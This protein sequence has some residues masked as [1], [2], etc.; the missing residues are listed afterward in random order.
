MFD[1]REN[2]KT[3]P[4]KPGVYLHKDKYGDVIYVGKASSLKNRVNQ[5]FHAS[6]RHDSKTSAMVEHIVEFEYIVTQTEMEALLLENNLI[7]KYL[8]KYNVMLRDD[9]TYPYIKITINEKYPRLLKTRVLKHDGSKYFGPY[10]DVLSVNR[11]LDLLNNIYKL[12]QCSNTSFPKGFRPCLNG[13]IDKCRK[14]CVDDSQHEEYMKDINSVMEFLKGKSGDVIS[15]LTEKMK[16]ASESQDYENA[17]IYRDFILSARSV[18][19]KQRVELLSTGDI[20]IVLATEASDETMAQVTLFFV[21][22]GRLIGRELH[23]LD[24]SPGDTK[25]EIVSAFLA[26]YYVNQT[27]IPKEILLEEH[28]PDEK[29][30]AEMLTK[31]A[32]RNV[33]ISI[34]QKGK[35]RALLK[36]TQDDVSE[37]KKLMSDRIAHEQEKEKELNSEI[38]RTLGISNKNEGYKYRLEAYDI[39]NTG[40]ADS[41]GAMVVF[42]GDKPQKR[43]YRKFKVRGDTEGDD[44]AA[45][46]EVVYR[47]LKRGLE[48]DKGFSIMPDLI[49]VDGGLGHVNAVN[50]ILSTL[51]MDISVAGMVKDDKHRTR[52]LIYEGDEIHLR[53]YPKLYHLIGSIQEE[54]HRFVI[55]YH[56][57][58]RKK[59]LIKSELD[60]IPG[61]G[62]KRRNALL[63]AFGNIDAIKEAD[64]DSIAEIPG[65]NLKVAK[66]IR[67]YF[68]IVEE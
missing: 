57:G 8:P 38:A 10:A 65:M 37:S 30:V 51:N 22:E 25:C 64:V 31:S 39:S 2:L 4:N 16:L 53:S 45:M 5:Y 56:R 21:R 67:D 12:K 54:V 58:L 46:Q 62:E 14:L 36:L 9:K 43:E 18:T 40:G 50:D 68:D 28:I 41:V 7:K 52:G 66:S 33:E 17:A 47:R 42:I 26:Q 13:H 32:G 34:P 1:I 3:L 44:Y 6:S 35:K 59:K 15:Y 19:E 60:Q 23:Y 61:I 24:A 29:I 11:I 48:G 55:E 27:V 20:D 63:L 49:L